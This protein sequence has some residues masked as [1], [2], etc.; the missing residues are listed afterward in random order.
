MKAPA[1]AAVV[2]CLAAAAASADSTTLVLGKWMGGVRLGVTRSRVVGTYGR[3]V[4]AKRLGYGGRPF[5]LD[6][7]AVHGGRLE[8]YYDRVTLRVVGLS[9]TSSV[10]RTAAGFGVGSSPAAARALGFAWNAQC[11]ATYL[12]TAGGIHYEL[13]TRRHSRS[14]AVTSVLFIRSA[15]AGDC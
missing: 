6:T 9:T 14:G 10:Y 4:S 8:V 2:I 1:L 7:Y 15:Y 5:E 11:T 3:P 13:A 12:K